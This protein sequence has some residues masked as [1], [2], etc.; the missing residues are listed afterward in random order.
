[1]NGTSRRRQV[2]AIWASLPAATSSARDCGQRGSTA[3]WG[4]CTGGGPRLHAI[5]RS[6]AA[7]ALAV[8]TIAGFLAITPAVASAAGPWYVAPSPTGVNNAACGLAPGTPC[9]TVSFVLTKATFASGDTINVAAGTYA[10]H[11]LF[12]AKGAVIKGAGSAT[13]GTVFDG[14]NSSYAIGSTLVSPGTISLSDLTLTRGK[15]SAGLG[16]GLALAGSATVTLT[17]VNVASNTAATGGGGIYVG[18]GVHV[19]MNGGTISGNTSAN[20][21]GV[22]L[23]AGGTFTMNGST[24]SPATISGNTATATATAITGEGGGVFVTGA[25]GSTPTGALVLNGVT[26]SGNAAKGGAAQFGGLGAGVFNAGSTTISG[27]STF[28][29]NQVTASTNAGSA[30]LAG[31][32][33]G[34]YSQGTVLSIT[35]TAFTNNTATAAGSNLSF[36]GGVAN[37][38]PA[39]LTRTTFTTNTAQFGGG[40][41]ASGSATVADSTFTGNSAT[42]ASLGYGGGLAASSV[43]IGSGATAPVVTVSGSTFSANTATALGGGVAATN[44]A[45]VHLSGSTI[46]GGSAAV[47]GG[48]AFNSGVMTID[49]THVTNN[50]SQ[51]GAGIFNGSGTASDT[52]NLTVTGSN[53]DGNNASI[54][55]GGVANTEVASLI[56]STVSNNTTGFQGG[57]IYNGSSKAFDA[58]TLTLTNTAVDGNDAA[59]VGGG[60][61]T[62]VGATVTAIGG[63]VS[64]NSALGGGALAVGDNGKASFDSTDFVGNTATASIGGAIA[65]A[66]T[67]SVRRALIDHNTA[68]HTTGVIGLGGAFYSGTASDNVTTSLT[69]DS[70]TI[71]NNDA[72]GGA[73]LVTASNGT[74]DTNVTSI[75]NSTITGN[76]NGTNV[77]SIEQFHPLTITN[78]T[79]TGNSETGAGVSGALYLVDPANVSVSGTILSGNSNGSCVST[80]GTPVDGGYNLSDPGDTSCGFTAAKH[81]VSANPQ[82]GALAN[83]GGDTPTQLPGPTSPVLDRIP[84]GTGTGVTNVVTG[85]AVTLCAATSTDQRGIAR[86]QG[87][88]CDIGSVEAQQTVPV[89]HVPPSDVHSA[90]DAVTTMSTTVTFTSTGSPQATL[91]ETGPLPSGLAFVD[92]GDG[93]A[94]LSGTPAAGTGGDYPITVKA[95]NE[96]GTGTYAFDIKVHQAPLL[97]GPTADTY[98]VGAPG[99]PDVFTTSSGFPNPVLTTT[100][101]LPTGVTFTDNHDGT[102]TIQGTPDAGQGGVYTIVIKGAN[103]TPPDASWTFTLTVREGPT[104][105]GPAT[106]TALVGTAYHSADFTTTGTPTPTLSATGLPNGLHLVSNG[107]GTGKAHI[108]GT[109]ANGA[110]GTYDV[111]VTATNGVGTDASAVLHL[112]VNEAP[113]IT[114]SSNARVVVGFAS[115]IGYSADGFP[116]PSSLHEAGALPTGLTFHD[117]GNGSATISGTSA[118]GTEGTYPVTITASNGIAPDAVLHVSLVVAPQLQISTT[119]LPNAPVGSAY[120]GSV[121]AIGGQPTYSFT[122]DSGTLP[123][124]LHLNGDGTITGAATGPTGPSTFTVRVTDSAA[125][126]P[127]T[128]TKQ[129]T[130]TVVKGTTTLQV[131][132]VVLKVVSLLGINVNLGTAKAT[133]RGGDGQPIA[134]QLITFTAGGKTVCVGTTGAD[135]TVSCTMSLA[136]TLVTVLNLGVTGTYAGNALWQGSSGH[137]GLL[138]L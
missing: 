79:I 92:N 66:G 23:A 119:S 47:E 72:W 58:P 73:A 10:D 100:S 24:A 75:N 90:D 133:L 41:F 94:T 57:G 113:E 13:G 97:G 125:P 26:V 74:G 2:R 21:A 124:G 53:I 67:L 120:S 102:A 16:G 110:G 19:T 114:G 87:A 131:E 70:S 51:I 14:T 45:V 108:E 43:N 115:T 38:G 33:G 12:G 85:T 11:P 54:G 129:L 46:T 35:D 101:T 56:A 106:D 31:W 28:S 20:G 117:N 127:Q 123:A 59:N 86:P 65:N 71:S 111:T 15:P 96:A 1:M 82:L 39:S 138:Q 116:G 63:E 135:G 77:G 9:A 81:D 121:V 88:Q 7:A 80:N 93:T 136:N 36:G 112:T 83:N 89:I 64:G 52:P 6:L 104:I 132:P 4:H 103:G 32:G 107:V 134:G 42:Q 55:G 49:G 91:S 118:T 78:S 84:V 22:Y 29:G 126:T 105:A 17:N 95:T 40:L 60:I 69:V 44:G 18:N 5:R 34:I 25:S 137:N 50:T 3:P 62:L 128:A 68:T 48:G 130:I 109:P 98:T 99:G 30:G 27:T 8:A 37:F 61:L 122:L 76:T